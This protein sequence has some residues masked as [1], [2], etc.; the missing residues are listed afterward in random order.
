MLRLNEDPGSS[1]SPLE[2]E[3][4]RRLWYHLCGLESKSAEEASS[5]KA[6]I[7]HDHSVR[8]PS[9]LNDW[10]VAPGISEMPQPRSGITEST[11][12]TLRFEL[13]SLIFGLIQ[14]KKKWAALE[15]SKVVG[16]MRDEQMER[17]DMTQRRIQND[18]LQNFDL[19]RPHDW[20]CS[21]FVSSML[22]SRT[23]CRFRL[24]D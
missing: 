13:H 4:R 10:D 17:L 14:V 21:H 22:V 11:F 6:S 24:A 16:R 19:S 8:M 2:A 5:R 18:Y 15:P 12:V 3:L 20:M 9:N 1:Y 7:L 23:L